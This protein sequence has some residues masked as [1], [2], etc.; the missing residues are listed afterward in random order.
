MMNI[1]GRTAFIT[2]GANGIG[3]GIA[4]TLAH[5]GVKIAL[6]DVDQAA[7]ES[8]QESIGGITEV[9][10]YELDV[11]DRRRFASIADKVETE[12]GPVSL[13]FNNAGVAMASPVETLTYEL[14]DW[15]L[16]INLGGVINGLQTFLP[17]MIDRQQGGHIVNTSSGAG[18]VGGGKTGVLYATSKFAL[19]GMSETLRVHLKPF[20]I[21]V[22]VLCPGPVATDISKRSSLFAKDEQLGVGVD[23][24][25]MEDASIAE[26]TAFL[27]S[28]KSPDQV[29]HI[30]V[31]A[32]NSNRL[33]I[34]TD[35]YMEEA[36]VKRTKRLLDAMPEA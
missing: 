11:R 33:Y 14:W 7:L 30:V 2:G 29:G 1:V 18:L 4:R 20:N 16:D 22:S 12:L 27:A 25:E 17:R 15:V 9:A 13:L 21:G 8:A 23:D 32:I 36:I 19:V 26:R 3:L 31:E 35:R 6:T 34:H 28:G 24:L 10:A 5:K